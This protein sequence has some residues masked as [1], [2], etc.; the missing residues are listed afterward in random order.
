M[1][2][3]SENGES[4]IKRRN[5]LKS[6]AAAGVGLGG[7]GTGTVSGQVAGI[8]LVIGEVGTENQSQPDR[9]TWHSVEFDNLLINAIGILGDLL[10]LEVKPIITMK[11]VSYNGVQP[12]HIRLRNVTSQGFEYRLEEWDYQ[13]GGHARELVYWTAILPGVYEI[14][15]VSGT[16]TGIQAGR[17]S[18]TTDPETVELTAPFFTGKP[19]VFAQSQTFNGKAD[20]IVT[21]VDVA[22]E[23]RFTVRLQEQESLNDY[24]R[25]EEVGYV[26]VDVPAIGTFP[27]NFLDGVVDT[28]FEARRPTRPA[29]DSAA[30]A[31]RYPFQSNGGNGFTRNPRVVAD[32]QTRRGPQ[33]CQLRY[34]ELERDHFNAFVEEE[35]SADEETTHAPEDIGYM[36]FGSNGLIPGITVDLDLIPPLL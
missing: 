20:S 4:R 9:G 2:R 14:P 29:R 24:H 16:L 12:C 30:T 21:R 6:V 31:S 32:I 27:T 5:Y 10:G 28:E 35:Q 7:I 15:G 23:D 25:S 34:T 36:A 22:S 8:D 19:A 13:D 33:P 18:T 3:A 17:V 1:Q 26:A 11:P